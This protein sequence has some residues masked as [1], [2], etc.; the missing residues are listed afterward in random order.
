MITLPAIDTETHRVGMVRSF[1]LLGKLPPI[2][3]QEVAALARR[4]AGAAWGLVTLVDSERL[5]LSGGGDDLGLDHCRWSSFCTHTIAQPDQNLWVEDAQA[6]FRFAGLPAVVDEP[7]IRF[8]AGVPIL[9]NDHAVG[10]VCVFDA[11]P[12]RPDQELLRHLTSL[13]TIVGEDLSQRHRSQALKTA[14]AASADALIDCDNTGQIVGWS[15]GAEHLFGFTVLEAVGRNIDI[16]IPADKKADHNRGF[17]H[18]RRH[19]GGRLGRRLELIACHKDGRPVE[20]ELWMSL[21]IRR[22]VPHIHANIRDISERQAQARA[23]EV[24]R[25]EAQAASEAKSTFLANMSHELR[26]P[27]NGVIGVI[28]LLTGT[29]LTQPQQELAELIK[30]SSVHLN[31][32][33]GDILDLAK[34]EAG[35][36]V[37]SS[38]ELFIPGVVD[39]VVRVSEVLAQ[40]KGLVVQTTVAADASVAVL[41][42]PVR[43]KQVLSNLVSNAVKFTESGSIRISVLRVG[44]E[45]RFE[46]QDTGI[47]FGESEREGLFSRFQQADGTITR[48]Y[49]GSGLGLAISRDLVAA[50]GGTIDCV[51]TKGV[52]STFWFS[53][54]LSPTE[55]PLATPAE[56]VNELVSAGRVLVVDDNA[57]NR[58]VAALLL[59][60]AGLEVVC[61]EDGDQAVEAFMTAS[62]DAIFMDMM[63]PVMDGLTATMAIRDIER[64]NALT[65]TAIIML[66]ANTLAEHVAASLDAGADLHLPKPLSAASLMTALSQVLSAEGNQAAAVQRVA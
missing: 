41:G 53:V 61:V 49:G 62:F 5:W 33:I 34:I 10:T 36:L 29:A 58:R 59:G 66:T 54:P 3:H 60:A 25:A 19:G 27:L 24:A 21:V 57:T 45:F 13:A 15:E 37:I 18:W 44:R 30:S 47:G 56:E 8:Y 64:R 31:R 51:S 22:G 32:L 63:M 38:S 16:I 2:Q 20:I 1:G 48:R 11:E 52:G 50:M 40:E 39:E 26:T 65:R 12:R 46:V 14:L 28:D 23:L 6:D 7:R 17:D 9:V 42:D 4:L 43:L 55:T 35:E